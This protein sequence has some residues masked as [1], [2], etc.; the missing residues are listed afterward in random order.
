MHYTAR[1]R[2]DQ[3]KVG[4]IFADAPPEREM[5]AGQFLNPYFEIPPGESNQ[6]VD[7]LIEFTDD[8]QLFALLP[9]T[10]LR[11]KRWEYEIRYPDGRTEPLLSV[12]G[13]DFNWQTY[14]VFE[15]PLVVP[16]GTQIFASAWYDN[17]AA[18]K[19]NPR[20]H[21]PGALGRADVGGDA[22]HGH[23]LQRGR[24]HTER[25]DTAAA[26]RRLGGSFPAFGR[27]FRRAGP[28]WT[29][30]SVCVTAGTAQSAAPARAWRVPTYAPPIFP[31]PPGRMRPRRMAD[32]LPS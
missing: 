31:T 4:L 30:P 7:S 26:V 12:P 6:Q 11:G 16:K 18:N 21:D 19:A 25:D 10:H 17:S 1:D 3:S 13:Y 23:H 22:V 15:E 2:K 24:E 5:I 8:A 14:Y 20:C 28:A 27:R 32:P 29:R 9:H